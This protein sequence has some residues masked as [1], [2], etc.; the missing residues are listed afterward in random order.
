MVIPRF[1]RQAIAGEPI[2]VYG[3]GDQTRAFCYVDDLVN[4]LLQLMA[5]EH[6]VTGPINLG[7]PE[8]FSI[9]SLAEQIITLTGS[10]SK[11]ENKPLPQDDPMQRCPD[12]ARA[13]RVLSWEPTTSKSVLCS[14]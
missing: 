2:T 6:E 11:I 13:R 9:S 5:T 4:G 14:D 12:I 7:N 8:E 1:I 10:R 3:D